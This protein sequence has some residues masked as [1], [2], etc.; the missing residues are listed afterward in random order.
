MTRRWP[1]SLLVVVAL[2]GAALAGS[3]LTATALPGRLAFSPPQQLPKWAGGEPSIA[4]DPNRNGW[5]YV[6]A[7]QSIPAAANGAFGAPAGSNGIGFWRSSTGGKS[8]NGPFS[9]AN[10]GA[11]N[12]GGDSDVEVGADGTVYVADLEAVATDICASK[13]H[14][15]SFSAGPLLPTPCGPIV[16]NQQGPETDRQWLSRA[17]NGDLLLT[18]HDFAAGFPIILKST[19][20]AQTFLP[21]GSILNPAQSAGQ[22]YTPTGG[23][24]VAKPAIGSDGTVYVEV[25]EPDRVSPPI[26]ATLN[27]LYI[28]VSKG[29]CNGAVF[30]NHLIFT[31]PTADLGKIFNALAVDGGDTL[32]VVAG[33]KTDGKQADT[34]I[35]LFT[36]TDHGV[37]WSK[38]PVRVNSPDLKANVLP[39]VVGGL[40]K[41]QVAIGWFG[42]TTSGDP[43]GLKN[44]WRYYAATSTDSGKTFQQ[45]TVTPG[46]IHYGDICTQ[47]V[48]CGLVPGQPSNRNLADFSSIAVDPANGCLVIALPGD[49]D[50]RPDLPN[51]ANNFSSSAYVS[52]QTGGACLAAP[53]ATAAHTGAPAPA[54]A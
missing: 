49:P 1:L 21:C 41:G 50:N 38:Q 53:A 39:A 6:V 46:V 17:K 9:N 23:T 45:T 52:S 13:D 12:G 48:F 54:A 35:W 51:G 8:W 19:D 47:G 29:G 14:G 40:G 33:G 11:T 7:P 25:T 22:N 5:V 36:S 32:Y 2:A 43:N 15:K 16:T 3:A 24:L 18:Y 37:T 26:G 20:K 42:T 4:F 27:H 10:I 44:Q 28:A 31:Q 34:N 30:D